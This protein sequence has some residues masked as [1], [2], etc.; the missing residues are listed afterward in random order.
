MHI[1]SYKFGEIVVDGKRYSADVMIYPDKVKK[2]WRK[3][4]HKVYVED[5]K[6]AVAEKPDVLVVGSGDPGLMKVLPKTK[7]YLEKRGIEL[8][9][10][11]TE[12]AVQ[13]FNQLC[14]KK[15]VIAGL[16]L[17]C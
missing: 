4:G 12:K 11:P 17:T 16:H 5:I 2:W 3:E 10:E 7:K 1:D 6:E 15:K 13:V 9:V 14:L 8:I